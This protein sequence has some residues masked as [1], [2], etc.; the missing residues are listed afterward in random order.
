MG[1]DEINDLLELYVLDGLGD[2]QRLAVEAHL[3]SCERCQASEAEYRQWVGQVRHGADAAAPTASFERGLCEKL[4]REIAAVRRQQRRRLLIRVSAAA[5]ACILLALGVWQ[6]AVPRGQHQRPLGQIAATQPIPQVWQLVGAQAVATSS[7]DAVVIHGSRMYILLNDGPLGRVAALD[8]AT[9]NEL[10]RSNVRS[11]GYLAAG[12]GLVY[13]LVSESGSGMELVALDASNGSVTWR[14]PPSGKGLRAGPARPLVL[15]ERRV[16]WSED[17]V[18]SVIDAAN[19]N[20]VWSK[21]IVG[22]GL[23]SE[24]APVGGHLYVATATTL[25]CLDARDGS[26]SWKMPLDKPASLL[27][28]PLLAASGEGVFVAT[29]DSVGTDR[30]MC[31]DP[32]GR[33]VAWD[34]SAPR[35]TSLLAA[36]G[37]LFVR[38]QTVRALDSATGDEQWAFKASGCGPATHFD[39]RVYFV[40]SSKPGRLVALDAKAGRKTWELAGLASCDAFNKIG[41][42]GY[43]KTQ[44]GIVHAIALASPRKNR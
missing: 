43:L 37:S 5:A 8:I 42:T 18:V 19:G 25:Y 34:K 28:R 41:D 16:C 38:G 15:N 44:D 9:G 17:D 7:A 14:C 22:E 35:I 21:P 32:D 3:R 29:K 10:W 4:G 20:A 2:E 11:N 27:A 36:E 6:F 40:D 12:D 39:G 23:V 13:C 31:V 1:C 24:A 33:R 30:L 26:E